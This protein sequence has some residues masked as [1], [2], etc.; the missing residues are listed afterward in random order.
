MSRTVHR[1][2]VN[3]RHLSPE[4]Y[5]HIIVHGTNNYRRRPFVTL[6]QLL[7]TIRSSKGV[8]ERRETRRLLPKSNFS[9][10][11]TCRDIVMNPGLGLGPGLVLDEI[12][13]LSFLANISRNNFRIISGVVWVS[14]RTKLCTCCLVNVTK[15]RYGVSY[16][17]MCEV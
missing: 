17:F 6:A 8:S 11:W 7:D 14:R 2:Q 3:H 15:Y 9:Q 5:R 13:F 1:P 16:I 10:L 4:Q 12:V